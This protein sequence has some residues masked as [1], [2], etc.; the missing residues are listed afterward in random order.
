MNRR[1][2]EK[3][4]MDRRLAGRSGWISRLDLKRETEGLPDV[5][6]K[7]AERSAEP[8]PEESDER[9]PEADSAIPR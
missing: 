1:S 2:L 4:R 5:S 7:I 3:L 8:R 9:P 6:G